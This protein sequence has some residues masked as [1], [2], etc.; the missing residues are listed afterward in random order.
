MIKIIYVPGETIEIE[1]AAV[2]MSIAE[3]FKL[4][5]IEVRENQAVALGNSIVPR[6]EFSKVH[7]IDCNIIIATGAKGHAPTPNGN[8]RLSILN[9][10]VS[11]KVHG[12]KGDH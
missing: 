7:I 12:G 8:Q 6:S 9:L 3:V 1:Q 11:K 2:G 10:K 5:A 4:A